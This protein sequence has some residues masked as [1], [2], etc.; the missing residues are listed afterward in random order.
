MTE[1][2]SRIEVQ[3]GTIYIDRPGYYFG[4]GLE[5]EPEVVE[6]ILG[7]PV[8]AELGVHVVE[9]TLNVQDL[10]QV[11][12]LQTEEL[13]GQSAQQI[14]ANTWGSQTEVPFSSYGLRHTGNRSDV[15]EGTLYE[16]GMY[17]ALALAHWDIAG[18][19]LG[20]AA[21]R[22]WNHGL[23]LSDDR[24]V[25]TLNI[26]HDQQVDRVVDGLGYERFLN[27]KATTLA[28]IKETMAPFLEELNSET[29]S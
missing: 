29:D 13:G 6:A 21:W 7:H 10:D 11:P 19:S 24:Q 14:I 23:K 20:E 8:V 9:H 12:Q 16:L 15:V 4:Y 17:D 18:P 27:D 1:I 22:F 3:P 26:G 2:V 5:A 25:M 28:I